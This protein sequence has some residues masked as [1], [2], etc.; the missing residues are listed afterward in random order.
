MD[1]QDTEIQHE[2]QD[3][4]PANPFITESPLCDMHQEEAPSPKHNMRRNG[5]WKTVAGIIGLLLAGVL[6][7]LIHKIVLSGFK[8]CFPQ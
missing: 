4:Y 5:F 3:L 2:E 8:R 7:L 6:S 1:Q